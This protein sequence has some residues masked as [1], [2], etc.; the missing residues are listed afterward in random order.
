[1]ATVKRVPGKKAMLGAW[2]RNG[3][4]LHPDAICVGWSLPG[5]RVLAS[6]NPLPFWGTRASLWSALA[7]E[8]RGG[9][10]V[11]SYQP[12]PSSSPWGGLAYLQCWTIL[13]SFTPSTP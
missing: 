6:C 4:F 7:A 9:S 13:S 10:Q 8:K 1:M 5:P 12:F 11:P 3:T 2:K